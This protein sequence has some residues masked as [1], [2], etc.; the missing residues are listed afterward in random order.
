M[1]RPRGHPKSGGRKPG[2]LNKKT[3]AYNANEMAETLGID[4]FQIMLMFAAGDWQGLGYKYPSRTMFSKDGSTYEID[5]IS[6]E[7]RLT[8]AKDA[9]QYL[10]PKRSA[11]DITG[12]LEL[13]KKAEEY[14]AMSKEEHIQLLRVE[15]QR[16]EGT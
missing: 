7:T 4:P 9:C 5:V 2:V 16:L 3:L 8:A 10:L 1:G 6:P 15:L 13:S 14:A 11:V 12:N